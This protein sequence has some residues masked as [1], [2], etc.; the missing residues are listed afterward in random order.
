[1]PKPLP[2]F[3]LI[4]PDIRS[5]FNVG[6]IFR[7]ADALGVT[8]IFLTGYTPRPP[9]PKINKVA[10]GA[11]DSVPWEYY[12]RTKKIIKELKKQKIQI[13]ALEKT[14]HSLDFTKFK[15]RW[16]LA[17]VLGNEKTGLKP[18]ILNE[19]DKIIHLPMLGKKESLNVAVALA[20]AAYFIRFRS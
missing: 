10:L 11:T 16:P 5:R 15:P 18:D 3:Y 2:I 19:A 17:L 8:K 1:M 9:H 12:P 4:V 13:V 20:A 14:K 6:A 7:T